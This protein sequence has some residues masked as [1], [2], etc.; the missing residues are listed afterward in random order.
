M[1]LEFC[2]TVSR[3]AA[4]PKSWRSAWPRAG[5][6]GVSIYRSGE[7]KGRWGFHPQVWWEQ[8]KVGFPP[9]GMVWEQGKVGFPSTGLVRAEEGG[10]STY[11]YGESRGRW[12]F[13]LQVWWEQGKVG[14]P[15]TGLMRAGEG[16]V[17]I[18]RSDESRGRSG[19]HLQVWW[20]QGKVRF[21][22]TGLVSTV[23]VSA[24]SV[25]QLCEVTVDL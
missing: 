19:F 2:N 10:V 5:E 22:S 3:L 17:S 11:R 14:F 25:V 12:G 23:P 13:H 18:Y 6:G 4:Q 9:T 7:S 16:G 15:P 20:G 24:A 21:I 1:D 8:R